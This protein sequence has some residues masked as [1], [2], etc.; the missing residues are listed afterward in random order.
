[1]ARYRNKTKKFEEEQPL[2]RGTCSELNL[3]FEI[4]CPEQAG[5]DGR[6]GEEGNKRGE[7]SRQTSHE[8]AKCPDVENVFGHNS[9]SVVLHRE[10]LNGALKR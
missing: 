6:E 2:S 8:D 10:R 9:K 7:T 1:M 3:H 4:F 5:V